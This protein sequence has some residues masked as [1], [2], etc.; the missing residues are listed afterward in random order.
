MSE[1]W[2]LVLADLPDRN[3]VRLRMESDVATELT[4][5]P[6]VVLSQ[7]VRGLVQNAIDA[8]PQRRG[9]QV[10]VERFA[11]H[12]TWEIADLG[13]GMAPEVL[14]RVSEPF[15]TT[16]PTGKGMGLGV[17]L[18]KNVIER[19]EGSIDFQSTAGQ[20]TKVTIRLPRCA[21]A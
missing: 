20:G 2:E 3:H 19:L 9:V 5:A 13:E 14:K 6:V 4:A 7:A 21:R 1:F 8:D 15:F 18:A 16:K 12:L 17:F 10:S 11:Q